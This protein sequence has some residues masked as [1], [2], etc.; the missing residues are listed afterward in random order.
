[1]PKQDI[2]PDLTLLNSNMVQSNTR[3]TTLYVSGKIYV[4]NLV[5][6]T[7]WAEFDD[8][9]LDNE[10]DIIIT[11]SKIFLDNVAVNGNIEIKTGII[12]G[13]SVNDFV[14]IDTRQILPSK[15]KHL[16]Y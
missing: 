1:M 8:L 2:D 3:F 14:T 11:G 4:E 15:L 12:N 7:G 6:G 9:I 13:H 16:I 5:N 10:E